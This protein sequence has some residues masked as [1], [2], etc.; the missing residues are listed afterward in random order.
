[1][2]KLSKRNT[3]TPQNASQVLS[4]CDYALNNSKGRNSEYNL[5]TFDNNSDVNHSQHRESRNLRVFDMVYV[6]GMRGYLLMPTSQQ[7]ANKLLLD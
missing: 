5:K 4:N 6:K 2:Q 3:C 1:M 7:K